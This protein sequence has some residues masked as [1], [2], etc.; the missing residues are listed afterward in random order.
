M[1]IL[2]LILLALALLAKTVSPYV[3]FD[4]ENLYKHHPRDWLKGVDPGL[5]FR[6]A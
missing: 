3:S 1:F 4:P 5:G 2:L 6:L